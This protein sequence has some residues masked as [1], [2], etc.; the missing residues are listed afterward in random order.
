VRQL[1][2]AL[3]LAAVLPAGCSGD[4][5]PLP[6][7][8]I[9]ALPADGGWLVTVMQS[10][11]TTL[12][13]VEAG[14]RPTA[15][16]GRLLTGSLVALDRNLDY[17][18]RLAESWEFSQHH[19]VLTFHLR[20]DVRWH[21][22]APFTADDVLY[23]YELAV[24]PTTGAGRYASFFSGVESVQAVDA[25][26]LQVTYREPNVVALQG[27]EALLMLPKHRGDE[28]T[29]ARTVVG[30]GPFRL[31]EWKTGQ[32]LTLVANEDYW[33]GRPHLQR[34]VFRIIP[35]RHTAFEALRA[36]EIDLALVQSEDWPTAAALP[37][38]GPLSF[39]RFRRLHLSYIAWNGDGSNPF[40]QD[41]RVRRAMTHAL[42]REGFIRTVLNGLAQVATSPI[43]PET[44]AHRAGSQPLA[45][46]L[47]AA[48]RLLDEAGWSDH[49]GD[50]VRDRDGV[51]FHFTL[52]V[53]NGLSSPQQLAQLL[54]ASLRQLGVE[55]EIRTLELAAFLEHLKD[56]DFQAQVS[57]TALDADPDPFDFWHS[58]QTPLGSNRAA[59]VNDEMDALCE[60]GRSEFDPQRRALLYAR[61]QELLQRD[62][63]FTFLWHPEVIVGYH[64]R[65]RGIEPGPLGIWRG[66]PST[67]EWWVPLPLQRFPADSA[68][69][70][71]GG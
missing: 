2:L 11:P 49:D 46:D 57:A 45:Y 28:D 55:M 44:W 27:W 17:R 16:L 32:E 68:A 65:L 64:R 67:L 19:R 71:Y 15:Q 9:G 66:Y 13:W 22:G 47:D 5:A 37:Q 23:T 52:F 6:R 58:S 69:T 42:D 4:P 54:Q 63:P 8:E 51:A 18:P 25:H 35:Q 14:D 3:L 43:M 60:E 70:A 48:A 41:P 59:Y 29:A 61:V 34:I 36:G 21:D 30:T 62:Q 39:L 38:D 10:D 24:D 20:R 12:R 1:G 31:L 7:T 50:G 56:R 33:G 40:F 26:T 53:Y